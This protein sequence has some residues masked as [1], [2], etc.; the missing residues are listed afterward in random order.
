MEFLKALITLLGYLILNQFAIMMLRYTKRYYFSPREYYVGGVLELT[1]KMFMLHIV[2]SSHCFLC[3]ELPISF[4]GCAIL[5]RYRN[6][7]ITD[8]YIVRCIGFQQYVWKFI[9][10]KTS[11][12]QIDSMIGSH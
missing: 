12:I 4:I 7:I 10:A 5:N 1:Q 9:S 3:L 2:K 11:F 6:F 8:G